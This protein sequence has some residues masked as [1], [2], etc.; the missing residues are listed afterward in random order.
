M[1]VCIQRDTCGVMWVCQCCQ[2]HVDCGQRV[3]VAVLEFQ[4]VVV[5]VKHI[6]NPVTVVGQNIV[7]NRRVGVEV[8]NRVHRT[9]A[10]VHFNCV[11]A[12]TGVQNI[13]DVQISAGDA[14]HVVTT[15]G[16]EHV[17]A[18][19]GDDGVIACAGV[20]D[21]VTGVV[22][23]DHR[24]GEGCGVD[25]QTSR[26]SSQLDDRCDTRSEGRFSIGTKDQRTRSGHAADGDAFDVGDIAEVAR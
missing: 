17:S 4:R 8:G 16:V 6:G 19:G 15:V 24:A 5:T 12:R 23:D 7:L 11:V 20:E 9:A 22:L 26:T 13:G 18:S 14:D 21:V 10:V 25:G 2:V 3:D 1:L